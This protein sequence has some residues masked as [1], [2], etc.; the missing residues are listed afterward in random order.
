MNDRSER[1]RFAIA[2]KKLSYT[3]LERLTGV[4]KSALQRYASGE[5]KKIPVDVIEKIADATGVTA[6]YLMGWEELEDTTKEK[7]T[8]EQLQEGYLSVAKYAQDHG[9]SPNDVLRI[10]MMVEDMKSANG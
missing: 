2:R 7:S 3:E 8:Q 10:M 9:I 1:I 6:K 5:T 4:S